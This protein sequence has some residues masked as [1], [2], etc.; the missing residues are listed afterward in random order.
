MSGFEGLGIVANVIA[1][2]DLSLK[3]ISWCSKYAQDVKDSHDSCARLLQ[4]AITL[5]YESEK[6]HELL[7]DERGAKLKA[8]RKLAQAMG[9]SEVQLRELE[10]L[11]SDKAN[12][13]SL[14]WP[15]REEKV[16]SAI[17]NIENATEALLEVL[18]M[19]TTGIILDIDDMIEA[20]QRRAAIDQLPY[21]SDA[22]W[23]S[24]AEE[25]NAT[26]LENTSEDILREIK[27][28]IADAT[29]QSRTVFW[30]NG[31]AGTGKSTISRTIAR[32]LSQNGTLGASFFFKR[33]EVNRG[34]ISK[35]VTTIA[36]Q[37][38]M[39][40]P[41]LEP[42]IH[43]AVRHDP[44]IASKALRNQFE[45]LIME[46]LSLCSKE[47]RSKTPVAI[48]IDALDEC[49]NSSVPEARRL[50]AN[51]PGSDCIQQLAQRASPLFIF[52]ATVCRFIAD[53]RH[54]DPEEQ[55]HRFLESLADD[56][57]SR[58]D[59]TY[60][61][62]L[63]QLLDS[64]CS[65]RKKDTIIHEVKRIVGTIINLS[66]PLSSSALSRLVNIDRKTIDARLDFLHS[67]FSVP[68]SSETPIRML[69]LSFGDYLMDPEAENDPFWIDKK[70]SARE[71][72]NHQLV[73]GAGPRDSKSIFDFL[74]EH[75]LHWI[76]V[77]ALLGRAYHINGLIRNLTSILDAKS[78]SDKKLID[79]LND[80]VR[81]VDTDIETINEAPL[82]IY[83]SVL[84]FAPTNSIVRKI[85]IADIP[86]WLKRVAGRRPD[87]DPRIRSFNSHKVAVWSPGIHSA[88]FSPDSKLLF[89][90][91]FVGRV[92]VWSCDTGECIQELETSKP[93]MAISPNGKYLAVATAGAEH[94]ITILVLEG[95]RH[96]SQLTQ[97]SDLGALAFSRDSEYLWACSVEGEVKAWKV[98]TGKCVTALTFSERLKGIFNSIRPF[99]YR[100]TFSMN[101]FT[102][103]LIWDDKNAHVWFLE[104]GEE[105]RSFNI[106]PIS[107]HPKFSPDGKVL[108]TTLL[109]QNSIVMR[110]W[111]LQ[112][113]QCLSE[114]Q[115]D[116]DSSIEDFAFSPDSSLLAVACHNNSIL[117]WDIWRGKYSAK[118]AIGN[119]TKF[120][121]MS[122]SPDNDFLLLSRWSRNRQRSNIV[123][124]SLN[125]GDCATV[126]RCNS[127]N[128]HHL[129]FSPDRKTLVSVESNG[130]IQL[131]DWPS[132][133][134]QPPE[135]CR[136]TKQIML[137]HD[138]SVV[139][140]S[141]LHKEPRIWDAVTGDMLQDL[142]TG[143][144]GS[145]IHSL[146]PD[147]AILVTSNNGVAEAP[148]WARS[149]GSCVWQP[150][151]PGEH[152]WLQLS[153][154][155]QR[156]AI[157]SFHC[158]EIWKQCRGTFTLERSLEWEKPGVN[159]L[160]S[161]SARMLLLSNDP[162]I[163]IFDCNT[164]EVVYRIKLDEPPIS[165]VSM[166]VREDYS[167]PA[168]GPLSRI[169]I[170]DLDSMTCQ[171]L[172]KTKFNHDLVLSPTGTILAGRS[173]QY[174]VIGLHDVMT[175]EVLGEIEV[176]ADNLELHGFL[177]D[178]S[179]IRTNY[180]DI[181]ARPAAGSR[182]QI[183]PT[184]GIRGAWIQW[185]G[186]N[187]VKIPVD[188]RGINTAVSG[189]ASELT[190]AFG[191]SWE[192][193]VIVNLS[194]DEELRRLLPLIGESA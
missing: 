106:T 165:L 157:G 132:L 10:R 170:W 64:Q 122:F 68:S 26:C 156:I 7:A 17:R 38:A 86:G 97:D 39:N 167:V 34:G 100:L 143:C 163:G 67:V 193:V 58:M 73:S 189:T 169:Q 110:I 155:F 108:A 139:A 95:I 71:L 128:V 61:P 60:R 53:R 192:R 74:E 47:F 9:S 184:F 94:N 147:F 114:L 83:S 51:W 62:V 65:K 99:R 145:H 54:G 32:S 87:W 160:F 104:S 76:E 11:L 134:Q 29:D 148:T 149:D 125:T 111:D 27:D 136:T 115:G 31:M 63:N 152:I 42:F 158:I 101:Y 188:C 144:R 84:A 93:P 90:L 80:A 72:I 138:A 20:S 173:S 69:H 180:G 37:L 153:R 52:A 177:P 15:L 164:G 150:K 181:H 140:A 75:L 56:T 14:R 8:S 117:I 5:H 3:V 121:T 166:A 66:N 159:R 137:S 43:S 48:V 1:V 142:L 28:W 179:G 133:L 175:L 190:I 103:L 40:Q 98:A 126:I 35:F 124:W 127:I 82:Q 116:D 46:P 92:R 23:D 13:S 168:F 33:G 16:E 102:V 77:M 178:N 182:I 21:V 44:M 187:L 191:F 151:K 146:L 120:A 85:F 59:Q 6:I 154:D 135:D 130:E 186:H 113:E 19:D 2:V 45:K 171:Y 131:W 161:R 105:G 41:A 55:L 57:P 112:G 176:L 119:H 88:A 50:P 12:Y 78:G 89:S 79:F 81:F 107:G 4:T 91:S 129:L 172:G 22:V 185:R 123:V 49:W 36:R 174:G 24:H 25:H 194:E 109:V 96:V 70:K 30:L 118:L 18:Q 183:A 162:E 141:Y